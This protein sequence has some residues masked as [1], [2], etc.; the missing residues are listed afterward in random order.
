MF[1]PLLYYRLGTNY[2][3]IDIDTVSHFKNVTIP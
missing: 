2:Y 3:A 1:Y